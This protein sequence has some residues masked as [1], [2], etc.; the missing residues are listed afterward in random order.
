MQ[1]QKISLVVHGGAGVIK[2]DSLSS[3]LENSYREKLNEALLAGYGILEAGG[4][5]IEAV[6]AT[7]K[8]L[9][10]SPLFNAG[11]GA[12]F[13]HEETI[14]LDAAIMDGREKDAGAVAGITSVKNP[15]EAALEVMKNSPHVMLSGP[16]AEKF[17]KERGLEIVESSYFFDQKRFDQLKK[18]KSSQG[19]QGQNIEEIPG[20]KVREEKFGTV[21]AV[22][23]DKFG[24]IAAG[25][26]TG[27]M[28]N[29]KW[30]RI[31]DSPIIG[32]GTYADNET[33][34]ISAT[35]HGEYFIRHQVAYD[36]AALMKYKGLSVQA[37]S[38]EVIMNKLAKVGGDGGIIALDKEG[39]FAMPFNTPGMY[40]GYIK[41]KQKPQIFIFKD[42]QKK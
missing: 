8:I 40:R 28:S 29:K 10:D 19:S 4:T 25:T 35:G 37:A 24:N 22:A 41:Y 36:V 16:G 18:E 6:V 32:A 11:K 9:E 31:G 17:A 13:S 42:E 39:N 2:R 33:C 26:S 1:I 7:I 30:G 12:V 14:E 20:K 38:D 3:E 5:S 34:G 23:L 15:I 27:G 21:G